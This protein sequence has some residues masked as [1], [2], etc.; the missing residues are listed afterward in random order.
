MSPT[1]ESAL[2]MRMPSSDARGPLIITTSQCM[3]W[4]E[5]LKS[6]YEGADKLKSMLRKNE[7]SRTRSASRFEPRMPMPPTAFAL[8]QAKLRTPGVRQHAHAPAS[9]MHLCTAFSFAG[10]C[11]ARVRFHS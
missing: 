10:W 7:L 8:M 2:E 3:Q 5:R 6:E 9:C 1:G 11:V 4:K